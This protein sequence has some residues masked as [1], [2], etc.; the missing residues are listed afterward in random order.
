MTQLRVKC[1]CGI[2]NELDA[3]EHGIGHRGS[4]FMDFDA[5]SHDG[6]THRWLVR[7]LKRPGEALDPATRIALLDLALEQRWTV[8]YLQLWSSGEIAW[9]DMRAP[10]SIDVISK[11]EYRQRLRD[12]WDNR[13][14]FSRYVEVTDEILIRKAGIR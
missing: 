14:D 2:S 3:I 12:W 4:S 8:W 5:V 13:Y 11:D 9:A 1:K 10:E 6:P 7:E